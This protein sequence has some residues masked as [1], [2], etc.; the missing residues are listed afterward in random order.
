MNDD[1]FSIKAD[2]YV[3]ILNLKLF[4]TKACFFTK[5]APLVGTHKIGISLLGSNVFKKNF[6]ISVPEPPTI[7][8][9]VFNKPISTS[10]P[11]KF[12]IS[13][14]DKIFDY[15]FI[16]DSKI[17]NCPLKDTSLYCDIK[18]IKL[19]QGKIYNAELI[20][21]FSNKKV[22]TIIKT[23][24][25]MIE[26]TRVTNSSIIQNEIIYDKPKIFTFEF[27]KTIISGDVK[28]EKI[29]N[30]KKRIGV[31][32]KFEISDNKII[33][34]VENDLDRD[35][36]YELTIQN[37]ESIDGSI[38]DEDYVL[39]FKISDGPNLKNININNYGIPLSDTIVLTFDQEISNNQNVNQF[40]SAS[41]IPNNI[42][43][44]KNQ[45][46]INY[47]NAPS[48]ADINISVKSG[49]ISNFDIAQKDPWSFSTRTICHKKIDIGKSTDGLP[50]LAYSFGNGENTI[51]YIAGIHGNEISGKYL[52]D[53]WID[54]LEKNINNIPSNKKIII[55]PAINPDGIASNKRNNYNNVDLNR[56]FDTTDWQTDI[57]SPSNQLINGGGGPSPMSEIETQII[58]SFIMQCQPRLTL[59]FHSSANLLLANEAGNSITYAEAYSNLSGYR[60]TTFES[61]S[62]NYIITGTLEGWMSEK[63][64]LPAV[65]IELSSSTDSEFS[66]NKNALWAMTK[67]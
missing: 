45:I 37:I 29:S 27:N 1:F 53:S 48:C 36:L 22:A 43:K 49:I 23:P 34:N 12:N 63:L 28:L 3:K 11:I 35:S 46:F 14:V 42:W 25:K 57:F 24:I 56:N 17:V 10:K 44:N 20:R 26:A 8:A 66:K 52:M 58:V 54:E 2:G 62:F 19:S 61:N 18:D 39:S 9:S 55:I 4:S 31:I 6:K 16:V 5:Q 40:V 38:L 21:S 30:D 15:K 50:I 51:L 59:L 67:F 64:N 7:N 60:N 33:A 32:S 41:G 65:L 13:N 47:S